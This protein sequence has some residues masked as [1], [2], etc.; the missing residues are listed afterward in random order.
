MDAIAGLL[1]R[2]GGHVLDVAAS[3]AEA[4]DLARV[5]VEADD[6][7]AGLGKSD[8]QRQPDIAE[9]DDSNLHCGNSRDALGS[10]LAI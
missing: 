7:V 6:L 10:E 9:P 4:L 8:R 1:E 2:G 3:L 5:D